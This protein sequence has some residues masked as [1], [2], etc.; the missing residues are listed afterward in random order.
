MH[1]QFQLAVWVPLGVLYRNWEIVGPSQ[2]INCGSLRNKVSGCVIGGL[3]GTS[4]GGADIKEIVRRL[5]LWGVN[6]LF[7]GKALTLPRSRLCGTF[8][9]FLDLE[10]RAYK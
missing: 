7:V 3:Q 4:R 6:M 2:K 5:S 9:G 1:R 8:V 10:P